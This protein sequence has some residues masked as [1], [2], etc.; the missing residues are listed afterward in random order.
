MIPL[1]FAAKVIQ[2]SELFVI[3]ALEM[4]NQATFDFIRQHADADVRSVGTSGDQ[5]P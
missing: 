2:K 1:I 3:F 4:I 5:E